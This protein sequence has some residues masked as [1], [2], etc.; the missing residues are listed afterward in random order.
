[1]SLERAFLLGVIAALRADPKLGADLRA[2]LG[3]AAIPSTSAPE[4]EYER[5]NA[6]ARRV[7]VSPRQVWTFVRQG[8]P[9]IG[10]GR[11]RRIHVA[12]ALASLARDEVRVTQSAEVEERARAAARR[13]VRRAASVTNGSA[14]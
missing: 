10:S 6:F 13:D 11:L 9:V 4:V 2:A 1:M 5:A 8:M 12:P 14:S 7:G 3:P